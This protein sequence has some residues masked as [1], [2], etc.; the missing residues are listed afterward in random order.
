L[1][2]RAVEDSGLA[3]TIPDDLR[4]DDVSKFL[5]DHIYGIDF[6]ELPEQSRFEVWAVAR[7]TRTGEAS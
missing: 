2:T 6:L 4:L 7:D 3:D 1:L 5:G